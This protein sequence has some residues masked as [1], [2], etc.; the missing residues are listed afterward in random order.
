MGASTPRPAGLYLRVSTEEQ[1]QEGL[2]LEVQRERLES[3][4]SQLGWPVYHIY[5]D[6]GISGGSLHRPALQALLRDVEAGVVRGILVTKMDRL[7]RRLLDLLRLYEEILSPK[8]VVL[9]SLAESLDTST[10]A[11]RLFFQIIGSFAEFERERF[12]ERVT[13][14]M[15]KSA[16]KGHWQ[17][18]REPYGYRYDADQGRLSVH[19]REAELVRRI[20]LL[21]EGGQSAI[22][23]ARTLAAEGV[24]TQRNGK[25]TFHQVLQI[26]R[27]R[28]YLGELVWGKRT[29]RYLASGKA[30]MLPVPAHAVSCTPSAHDAIISHDQWQRVAE[31]RA[32]RRW[33]GRAVRSPYLLPQVLV[34]GECGSR[35]SGWTLR[36][37]RRYICR[38]HR[39][40]SCKAPSVRADQAERLVVGV[41]A[42]LAQTPEIVTRTAAWVERLWGA[43]SDGLAVERSRVQSEMDRL[44]RNRA[45]AMEWG[46]NGV[47]TQVQLRAEMARLDEDEARLRAALR[48]LELKERRQADA[49]SFRERVVAHFTKWP[50]VWEE[51]TLEERKDVLRAVLERAVVKSG[52]IESIVCRDGVFPDVVLTTANRTGNGRAS[53]AGRYHTARHGDP[54][55]EERYSD[56]W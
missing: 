40:G 18:G 53:R 14:G 41:L 55:K 45:Q 26:L 42:K 27:S 13:P 5:T 38:G 9:L 35:F 10:A 30:R 25:W 37:V 28:V 31:L 39:A 15:R 22:D 3:F 19:P 11:G 24:P 52:A 47:L 51:L 50:S 32:A 33:R 49:H 1:A 34:C 48:T 44:A 20:Y 2:S 23:I 46:Y 17:G 43:T 29:T 36:G 12:K 6:A 8:D 56:P 7:S 54:W 16:E 4:A 21:Y